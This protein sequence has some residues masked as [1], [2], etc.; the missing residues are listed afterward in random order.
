MYATPPPLPPSVNAGRMMT[1]YPM[2]FATASASKS[3][4]AMSEGIQGCPMLCIVSLNSSL[5]SALHIASA[6]VPMSLQLCAFK[7]PSFS[8]C[9]ESV[10]PVCPPNVPSMLSGF[11]LTMI[12][13]TVSNV[14]GSRYISSASAL[15]V[16][17]VAGL[18]LTSTTSMPAAFSTR[19]A[20]V[21]A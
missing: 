12:R 8:S 18:E 5:S 13:L 1:G 7:N 15:S 2:R 4:L 6:L 16:I 19:Q 20:C 21:P 9:I 17:I 11:S 10:S 14:S 3:S